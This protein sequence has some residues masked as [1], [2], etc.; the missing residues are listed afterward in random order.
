[1]DRAK[2]VHLA[3]EHFASKEV[4]AM[5]LQSCTLGLTAETIGDMT[6]VRFSV[7]PVMLDELNTQAFGDELVALTESLAA[8]KLLLD[9]SSVEYLS[10]MALGTLIGLHKRL[11]AVGG[12]LL[13]G[14]VNSQIYEIF[15][16]TKLTTYLHVRPD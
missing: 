13:I 11:L 6:I 4:P 2:S 10:S 15:E 3:E 9:F 1:M 8:R 5:P 12:Q 16:I 14:H 7:Q